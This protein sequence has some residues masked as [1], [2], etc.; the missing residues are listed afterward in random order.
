MWPSTITKWETWASDNRKNIP[1]L[2]VSEKSALTTIIT[3]ASL[4]GYGALIFHGS[5][6]V[7]ITAGPWTLSESQNSINYLELLAV[8]RAFQDFAQSFSP[9]EP[10][11]VIVDNT[12]CMWWIRKKRANN[13]KANTLLR[14]LPR[15]CIASITYIKS[16]D[17]PADEY[18]RVFATS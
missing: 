6:L 9:D 12:T 3:D 1:R 2:V 16:E 18:S 4:S 10:V 7:S 14:Y 17:N 11:N 13:Y 5:K 8:K 15:V